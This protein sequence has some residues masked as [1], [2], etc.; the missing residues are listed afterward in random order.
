MKQTKNHSLLIEPLSKAVGVC[1]VSALTFEGTQCF[2]LCLSGGKYLS[3]W[4]RIAVEQVGSPVW[5]KA[6]E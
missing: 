4:V 1:I 5:E 2:P 6:L 3:V